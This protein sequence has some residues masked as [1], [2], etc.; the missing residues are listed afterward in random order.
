MFIT[1][2]DA[3]IMLHILTSRACW[4]YQPGVSC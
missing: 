3:C 2:Y 1:F 4:I